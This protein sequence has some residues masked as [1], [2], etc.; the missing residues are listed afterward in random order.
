VRQ[1]IKLPLY[2]RLLAAYTLTQLAWS[3]GTLALAV[4]VY[5]RTGSAIGSAAFFLCS[6]F[7]PALISPAVVARID[8]N[9]A[10]RVL[11]LLYAL[12]AVAF[13]A[14]AWVSSHF[15]LGVLLALVALD[16][17]VALA[18]RALT[19]AATAAVTTPAGLLREGNALANAAFSICFFIGPAIGALVADAAGTKAALLLDAGMF[20]AIAV[21]LATASGL[22]SVLGQAPTTGRLRAALRLAAQR[23]PIRTLLGLQALG[24]I[25][26]T[27]SVPVEVVFAERTLNAGRGG[28]AALLSL[29]GAGTVV[30]SAV[31]ARWRTRPGRAMIALG[32]AVLGVGFL[33]MAAASSLAL[34]IAGAAI[35]GAGNGVQAVAARTTLQEQ[36]EPQWMA[37]IMSL[38]ESLFQAMPGVG[39]LLGGGLTE[40]AGTRA[41]LAV[42]G[43]GA[44]TIALA[45]WVVLGNRL[46]LRAPGSPAHA[47]RR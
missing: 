23:P 33:L 28:Y 4:L 24:L 37:M 16:G 5:G 11:P 36:V 44:L 46:S 18:A 29:W 38:N 31:Y 8:Q 22:P 32:S 13:V 42:A 15:A 17:V 30:G 41:A 6:Q 14:L 39:I 7:I 25:F 40:L 10:R 20:A 3:V 2:R 1:V 43:V 21:I 26:F 27:M 12:E 19:R 34:A 47:T 9:A 45:A 35:A